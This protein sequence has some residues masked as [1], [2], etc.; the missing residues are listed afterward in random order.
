MHTWIEY[1]PVDTMDH[2]L[3]KDKDRQ[4]HAH[5]DHF[6]WLFHPKKKNKD[7]FHSSSSIGENR[8]KGVE[9]QKQSLHEVLDP[10]HRIALALG[11]IIPQIVFLSWLGN[12]YSLG[13]FDAAHLYGDSSFRNPCP[14]H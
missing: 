2:D 11:C 8:K 7:P 9:N 10:K 6:P 1:H 4:K 12:G 3:G 13:Y 5:V 14:N